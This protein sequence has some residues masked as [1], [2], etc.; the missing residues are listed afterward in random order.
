MTADELEG[1]MT[2]S[3]LRERFELMRRSP[4]DTD[5]KLDVVIGLLNAILT[6]NVSLA[7]SWVKGYKP[8]DLPKLMPDWRLKR[9][10]AVPFAMAPKDVV[11]MFRSMKK[12]PA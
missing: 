8:P 6:A 10:K 4:P 1:R 9:K 3:E 2:E 7:G 12:R 5:A 11:A